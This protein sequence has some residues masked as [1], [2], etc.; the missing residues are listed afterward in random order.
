MLRSLY[1]KRKNFNMFLTSNFMLV[2]SSRHCQDTNLSKMKIGGS[3]STLSVKTCNPLDKVKVAVSHL[4]FSKPW[5]LITFLTWSRFWSHIFFSSDLFFGKQRRFV[6]LSTW[7]RSRSLLFFFFFGDIWCI[8]LS[9]SK[10]SRLWLR[11]KKW[12]KMKNK[13]KTFHPERN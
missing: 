12:E 13:I 10:G 5:R 9:S 2:W 4:F 7:S 1:R 8:T 6:T 3:K 11:R